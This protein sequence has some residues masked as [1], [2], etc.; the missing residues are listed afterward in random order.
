MLS[1]PFSHYISLAV[2]LLVGFTAHEFAHAWTADYFGDDT[3]R[4][5]GRLTL[6][7]L[8]HLDILGTLMM[9]L[10][11][12]GWAKPVPVNPYTLANRSRSV[13]MLVALSGPLANLFIAL[14]ASVPIGAGLIQQSSTS[15]SIF[16]SLYDILGYLVL[17]NLVLFFLNIIPLHPLDGEEVAMYFLPPAGKD[18]LMGLRRFGPGVLIVVLLLLP[19]LG[20][21]VLDWLVFRPA[22]WIT[23]LLL[24]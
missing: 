22:L 16:P 17:Y 19:S 21:P 1:Y 20:L 15:G 14:A 8:A 9:L 5:H 6:N 12:F 23:E 7:P 13:P 4:R 24:L 18:L 3:P 10:V 2:V 11:G